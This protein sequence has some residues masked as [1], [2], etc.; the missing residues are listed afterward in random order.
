MLGAEPG[1]PS[2]T[3]SKLR[4]LHSRSSAPP[5][6]LTLGP[7]P[8]ITDP[9]GPEEVPAPLLTPASRQTPQLA[10]PGPAAVIPSLGPLYILLPL[11]GMPSALAC[12]R[13]AF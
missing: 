5:S 3:A 11:P 2:Q 12:F 7:Q 4:P 10:V 1:Q 9:C 13:L 8:K 6:A